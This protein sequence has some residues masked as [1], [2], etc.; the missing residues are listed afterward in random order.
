MIFFKVDQ[1]VNMIYVHKL[2][3]TTRGILVN[4]C[5][6]AV[7]VDIG[8]HMMPPGLIKTMFMRDRLNE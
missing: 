5:R 1:T 2:G 6:Q 8:E 3:F 7:D 4:A